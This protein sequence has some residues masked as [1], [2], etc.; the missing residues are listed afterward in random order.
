MSPASR[1]ACAKKPG[2]SDPYTWNFLRA[3]RDIMRPKTA[4]VSH[5]KHMDFTPCAQR[6]VLAKRQLRSRA[7]RMH[8]KMLHFRHGGTLGSQSTR[9]KTWISIMISKQVH[10]IKKCSVLAL[11][12]HLDLTP[13]AMKHLHATRLLRSHAASTLGS[14]CVRK[15]KCSC[16]K[17]VAISRRPQYR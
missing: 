4:A 8:T 2:T 11:R 15:E 3:Q 12:A 16:E 10:A 13:C 9:K 1:P 14:L 17:T 6:H 5:R 7:A